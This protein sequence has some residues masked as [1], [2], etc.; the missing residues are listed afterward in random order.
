[1]VLHDGFFKDL[2]KENLSP[3]NLCCVTKRC[4]YIRQTQTKTMAQHVQK[5][6][7]GLWMTILK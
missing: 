3:K 6:V 5:A 4:D 1:M 2:V 7:C